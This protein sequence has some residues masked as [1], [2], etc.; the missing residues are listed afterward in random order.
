MALVASSPSQKSQVFSPELI[1]QGSEVLGLMMK[2]NNLSPLHK[3]KKTA[4]LDVFLQ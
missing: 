2:P 4:F 1:P 3:R